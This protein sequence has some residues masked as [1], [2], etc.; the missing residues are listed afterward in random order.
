MIFTVKSFYG[1]TVGKFR[2]FLVRKLSKDNKDEYPYTFFKE[3][4]DSLNIIE[5]IKQIGHNFLGKIKEFTPVENLFLVIFDQETGKFKVSNSIGFEEEKINKV[6]FLSKDP[7]A[8]WLKVNKTHLYI[9]EKSGVLRFLAKKERE[10]LENLNIELCF[11]LVSM[12]RLIG[13]IFIGPKT[14][15][16][17]FTK[18]ELAIISTLTPQ[19]GIALE[20]A[21]LYKEKRERFKRM[22]R[23]DKLATIGELAAGAAHEIRNPLTAIQSSLQYLSTKIHAEKENKLLTNALQETGRINEILSALLSFS[24]PSEIKKEENNI[25]EILEESLD[26]ISIQSNKYKIKITRDYP[27]TPLLLNSDKAQLK[28]LFL[29]ILL[30]S[31]QAMNSGGELKIEVHPKDNHKILITVTDTGE[32]IPEDK[33]DNIFD[34]FFTTKSGGTGLGLS[35]CYGII[36]SHKGEIEVKSK[37]GQGT[38]ISITLPLD[39]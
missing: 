32:G 35:I 14:K 6:F 18:Q 30:N 4:E 10:L 1:I 34:P 8:K 24:R 5:D 29:N 13:I 11:P 25:I 27:N 17:K 38:T 9:P 23:A 33:L 39:F 2:D 12:N 21:I 3:L 20:N 7:L 16:K 15:K 36:E 37:V 28:Q 26:L 19:A 31:A 22:S